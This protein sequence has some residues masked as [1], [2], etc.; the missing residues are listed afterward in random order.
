LDFFL[1]FIIIK[2]HKIIIIN[3][4][5]IIAEI[6]NQFCLFS[7]L[8]SSTTTLKFCSISVPK[9]KISLFIL[10]SLKL[11]F[12]LYSCP[13]FAFSGTFI[14]N[15][16]GT[17]SPGFTKKISFLQELYNFRSFNNFNLYI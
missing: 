11:I 8:G 7:F 15:L 12:I 9:L 1:I 4:E 3:E 10:T 6:F 14:L 16:I 2:I 5:R 13:D 17:L